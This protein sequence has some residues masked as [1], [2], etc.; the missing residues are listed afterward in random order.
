MDLVSPRVRLPLVELSSAS[1]A[2][3]DAVLARVSEKH[4]G[5]LIEKL[6]R[7]DRTAGQPIIQS[8]PQRKFEVVS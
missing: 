4:P 3:I 5:Y 2:E 1:R 8:R 7:R 6:A